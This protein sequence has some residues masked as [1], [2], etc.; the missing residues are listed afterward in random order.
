MK[1]TRSILLAVLLLLTLTP[2]SVFAA[3]GIQVTV[4]GQAVAFPDAKPYVNADSRTLTPLSPIAQAMDL[5]V[6]WDG[7]KKV[8]TFTKTYTPETT[9]LIDSP[10]DTHTGTYYLGTETVDFTIGSKEAV[11]TVSFYDTTDTERKTPIESETMTEK[12]VMDTEAIVKENRTYAPVKYLAETLGFEVIWDGETKT[13]ELN[14]GASL[15]GLD[16]LGL[17][18]DYC[19]IAFFKGHLADIGK[20][21]EMKIKAATVDGKTAEFQEFTQQEL[22]ESE[23]S[24]EGYLDGYLNGGRISGSFENGNVYKVVL[25]YDLTMDGQTKEGNYSF[26]L[27][28]DGYGGVM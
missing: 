12:I 28:V 5:E 20:V 10:D 9:P 21:T 17:D 16:L 13:A 15:A 7:T 6:A 8:A 24:Y 22:T 23:L 27:N 11:Y 26:D 3:D 18:S 19:A 4:D 14:S 2:L 25:T 1:K